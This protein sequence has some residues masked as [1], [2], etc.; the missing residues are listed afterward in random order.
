MDFSGYTFNYDPSNL[1][2]F[3]YTFSLDNLILPAIVIAISIVYCMIYVLMPYLYGYVILSEQEKAKNEK[4][5]VIKDLVLMNEIQTEL[6]KE[7]E[8]SLLNV[9][10]TK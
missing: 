7:I 8:Q 5:Q 10:M 3:S 6:E 1:W 9:A 4:R 2:V